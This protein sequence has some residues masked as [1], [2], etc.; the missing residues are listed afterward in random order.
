MNRPPPPMLLLFMYCYRKK[1]S[2]KWWIRSVKRLE[3]DGLIKAFR[4]WHS[5]RKSNAAPSVGPLCQNPP[6][7]SGWTISKTYLDHG[8]V[9]LIPTF[10]P[11]RFF[12]CQETPGN[13][14]ILYLIFHLTM[15]QWTLRITTLLS[16]TDLLIDCKPFFHPPFYMWMAFGCSHCSYLTAYG[17]LGRT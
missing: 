11:T 9:L 15:L 6:T 8:G 4:E 10:I 7:G 1:I 12:S 14:G 3:W 13:L 2:E 16:S 17:I 5:E